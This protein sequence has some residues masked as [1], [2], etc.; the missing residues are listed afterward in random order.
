VSKK[1]LITGATGSVA[2]LTIQSIFAKNKDVSLRA[3]VRNPEQ[4]IEVKR[5]RN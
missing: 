1:I 3:Y 5:T 2:G 4:G